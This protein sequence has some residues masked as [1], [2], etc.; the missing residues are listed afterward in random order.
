M[1]EYVG[2]AKKLWI[3]GNMN[4][5]KEYYITTA[6]SALKDHFGFKN[7]ERVP[8][9]TKVVLNVGSGEIQ[10]NKAFQD[11]L[12][13]ELATICGQKP[14]VTKAKKAISSFKVREGNDVGMSVTLRGERMYDFLDKLVS[15]T[16]PRV[17]DFRGLS[18]KSF[19]GSGNYSMGFK[20]QSVFSEIPYETIHHNH[21]LQVTITT[22]AKT[23]EEGLAL[24]EAL[25]F[26]FTKLI[27]QQ[28]IKEESL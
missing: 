23:N 13:K 2:Y 27:N 28:N 5:L 15:V 9:I 14:V 6:T 18:R 4:R 20:E 17:R 25:G 10:T 19:D 11:E 22:T 1:L 24:L 8:K 7:I 12:A 21:G 26:P 16:I 3:R